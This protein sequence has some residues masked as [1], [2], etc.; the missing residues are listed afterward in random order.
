M[1]LGQPCL[2]NWPYGFNGR[3]P[4]LIQNKSFCIKYGFDGIHV[5]TDAQGRRVFNSASMNLNDD[6]TYAFGDSQLLG[7]D[8]DTPHHLSYFEKESHLILHAAPNNGPYEYLTWLRITEPKRANRLVFGLNLSTD[9]FR[10]LP[11]WDPEEHILLTSDELSLYFNYP[12]LHY[13]RGIG[14]LLSANPKVSLQ[15]TDQSS[16]LAQKF[17]EIPSVTLRDAVDRM[18][19]VFSYSLQ[20]IPKTV[21]RTVVLYSPFWGERLKMDAIL[22]LNDVTHQLACAFKES[23]EA[24]VFI[25]SPNPQ[26]DS[27]LT[28]DRR[29]WRQEHL[30]ITPYAASCGV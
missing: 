2:D 15:T 21:P 25:A 4:H 19:E 30:E 16:D 27:A 23:V 8:S 26:T 10:I 17:S 22:K 24:D 12:L 14:T 28:L 6:V 29:H 1:V 11:G 7:Y 20:G 5:L 9:L 18:A 3:Y 13:L